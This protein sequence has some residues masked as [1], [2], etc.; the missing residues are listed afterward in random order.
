MAALF[1]G[2]PLHS[3]RVENRIWLPR[4]VCLGFAISN[5][6]LIAG[7]PSLGIGAFNPVDRHSQK[8][9]TLRRPRLASVAVTTSSSVPAASNLKITSSAPATPSATTLSTPSRPPT[10]PSD[11]LLGLSHAWTYDTPSTSNSALTIAVCCSRKIGAS[12]TASP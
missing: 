5:Q 7:Y 4:E 10:A 9:L 6:L 11:F 12:T 3:K 2:T 8:P 1:F